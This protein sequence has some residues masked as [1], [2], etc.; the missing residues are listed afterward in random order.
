V[1]ALDSKERRHSIMRKFLFAAV[2]AIGLTAAAAA[3]VHQS[4]AAYE[5]QAAARP[6]VTEQ[7]AQ[8]Q[9]AWGRGPHVEGD[10]L[11]LAQGYEGQRPETDRASPNGSA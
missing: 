4:P 2:S 9:V 1:A 10:R 3:G 7:S 8:G 6:P 11:Q 5:Q